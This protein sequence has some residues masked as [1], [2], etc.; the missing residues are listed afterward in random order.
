MVA[1]RV[2]VNDA[3]LD[4]FLHGINGPAFLALHK[5]GE[6]VL[7]AQKVK[8]PVSPKGSTGADGQHHGS[9]T[10]R[11]SLEARL[12]GQGSSMEV[13]VGSWK[14]D[15][16]RYVEFGTKPH[17]IR[18]KNP[19]GVLVFKVGGKTVRAKVVHHPGTVAQPFIRPSL[20]VLSGRVYRSA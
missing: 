19:D 3:A 13:Q 2:I 5:A 9:G 14:V 20:D 6:D 17:E 15:Y 7:Q 12:V 10:L 1:A 4:D 8:C 18:P 11:S 16:A